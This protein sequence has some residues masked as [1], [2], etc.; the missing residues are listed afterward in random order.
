MLTIFRSAELENLVLVVTSGYAGPMGLERSRGAPWPSHQQPLFSSL[1]QNISRRL[2][3]R[4]ALPPLMRR[5]TSSVPLF[6]PIRQ[7]TQ[8]FFRLSWR[9]LSF[10]FRRNTAVGRPITAL[11]AVIG[12]QPAL[13]TLRGKSIFRAAHPP[14]LFRLC[15][16]LRLGSPLS[17]FSCS[18]TPRPSM[19]WSRVCQQ[20]QLNGGRLSTY[21]PDTRRTL[22]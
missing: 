10:N 16:G 3:A 13:A 4:L 6:Q 21:S 7:P 12:R 1:R 2:R 18:I 14:M 9:R 20:T 5:R 11:M 17:P 15:H 22:P 8:P 19:R